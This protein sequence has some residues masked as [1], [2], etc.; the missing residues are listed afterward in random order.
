MRTAKEIQ[1]VVVSS[2]LVGSIL[3]ADE[4]PKQPNEPQV[5]IT[6]RFGESAPLATVKP[7]PLAKGRKVLHPLD[8]PELNKK[9]KK[10]AKPS[11]AR[12]DP[13]LQLSVGPLSMPGPTTSFDG[14]SNSNNVVAFGSDEIIPPDPN[15]DVGPNHYVQMVNL[16][17]RVFNKSTGAP[18]TSPLT[19][20]DVFTGFGGPCETMDFASD[21]I[22]LYD[23]L[24]DR[25]L[26]TQLAAE[27]DPD[28]LIPFPPFHECVACSQTPD[29]TGAYYLYDFVM[30][31]DWVNDYPKFG[32]WPD[33]YY[34]TDN[35]FDFFTEDPHGA[36]VF[37][38]DR[39][40]MLAGDPG[41]SYIFFN[42]EGV[43]DT[44]DG[45]LPADVD[46]PPP[47]AG[48][49]NYMTCLSA[50][51]FGD[52]V[53][54]MRVFE[55]HAD[56]AD[57]SSATFTE[58]AESPVAVAG[59]D[60]Q[61]ACG[62][63]LR[64]CIAQPPPAGSAAK[65]DALSDLLMQRLQYRNFG[66]NESLVVNHTVDVGGNHAGERYYQIKRNLPSGTFFVNE[67]ASYAPDTAHRWMGSAAMDRN[68]DLAV[69]YSVSSSS[70]FPS[71]RYAGRLASD[72]P[73]GLT[74]GETTLQAGSGSQT[75][76]SSRWGDYSMLAVDPADDCTFW[77]TS[78]YYPTNSQRL[79]RTRIGAFK[80]SGCTNPPMGTLKGSVTN[81]STGL[82]FVNATVRTADG[83]TRQ[84]DA[85]GMYSMSLPPATYQVTA[86]APSYTTASAS[87]VVVSNGGTTTQNFTISQAPVLTF[88]S[89][90]V[91]DSV[92]NN[93]GSIDSNECISLNVVLQNTGLITASNI[94]ATLSTITAGV[95]I[96]QPFSTYANTAV[97]ASR[98]NTTP[99]QFLTMAGFGCGAPIHLKLTVTHNGG[100]NIIPFQRATG[101]GV[102]LS[103]RFDSQDTP[104]AI[105]PF[106][107]SSSSITVTGFASSVAKVTVSFYMTSDGNSDLDIYLVGP[108]NTTVALATSTGGAFGAGYGTNCSPDSSRT[109]FDDG[110]ATLIYNGSPPFTGSYRPEEML[111]AFNG[112][113]A[114]A[115]NGIWTLSVG[116]VLATGSLECWSL[117]IS[118]PTC[119]N[120]GG[121]CVLAD[122]DGDGLPDAWEQ[123][124]FGNP[125][126]AVASAD[127]DGDGMSNLQEFLTGTNPTNHAS[128]FRI[129][130]VTRES[131]NVRIVW[132][133]AG[134][135]T[136]VVQSA[137]AVSGSYSNLSANFVIA[138]SGD[139]STNFLH[140]GAVTN[141]PARFYRIRLVP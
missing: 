34:M 38:F 32:V 6:V 25:W 20:G 58:R 95:T 69:G 132:K 128:A 112:K 24:A 114:S 4:T 89:S 98:T 136:N 121:P 92:G 100:T 60:P 73:N 141:T 81:A 120:G 134:G 12:F 87:G 118:P 14:L 79:W 42:L 109:T 116:N 50:L 52:P 51:D 113:S 76:T 10:K 129:T 54:G 18:L 84:T 67:Q 77:Y 104:L 110:A 108:D 46:G 123:Q 64:A 2:L 22:V 66:T 125:T 74:Q 99:F 91:D 130:S 90:A 86:S 59:F 117:N 30:P 127:P 138:G 93:N 63:T 70:V 15:G 124:Y 68:G 140:V 122:T 96:T 111:S 45:L 13:V 37:A 57:P 55:F 106:F 126:N 80:F 85:A 88:V 31:N 72:P 8:R 47:P 61:F 26:L 83:Y 44:I 5:G 43:D 1:G 36:G 35:Q 115:V 131:N 133:T 94:A 135:Y 28:F 33:A 82:P 3:L 75:D 56:F 29:P 78:E 102:G 39:A 7:S 101:S 16:L 65:L 139:T 105:D 41:A 23:P 48:T 21:P 53:D 27:V 9:S 11:A 17:L 97:S 119:A 19:I 107:G 71:I 137:S 62:S 103:T 40:K 49:P